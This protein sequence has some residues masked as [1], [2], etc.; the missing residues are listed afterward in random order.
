MSTL[1][2]CR[3]RQGPLQWLWRW[4]TWTHRPPFSR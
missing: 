3:H 4:S 2:L 1:W